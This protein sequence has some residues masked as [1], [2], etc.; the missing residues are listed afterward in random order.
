[1]GKQLLFPTTLCCPR[2]S[3]ICACIAREIGMASLSANPKMP[4]FR[5]SRGGRLIRLR[6]FVHVALAL[7]G[8]IWL[9]LSLSNYCV[10]RKSFEKCMHGPEWTDRIDSEHTEARD[11]CTPPSSNR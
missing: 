10:C 2:I 1:M 4:N 3:N 7:G 8:F 9:L 11:R 6:A 5:Y